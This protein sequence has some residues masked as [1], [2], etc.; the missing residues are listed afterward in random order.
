ME[1]RACDWVEGMRQ[2]YEATGDVEPIREV[3]PA[4]AAQMQ[5]FLNR[6]TD[7]GL[8]SARDWVVWGN[9]LGYLTGQTTTLNAFVQRALTDSAFLAGVIGKGE[10]RVKFS[11]A[12]HDLATAI[13]NVLW[14]EKSGGYYSGYFSEADLKA[15]GI[16][17]KLP[18]AGLTP[19]NL[20]ANVFALD[21]GIVPAERRQRVIEAMLTQIPQK[22]RGPIMI[23][24]Y[25]FKQL[26]ALDQ[27]KYDIQVLS[28]LRE[29]WK[30]M[31]ASPLQCSWE[32]FDGGSRAHIYGMYPG[33]FLSAYVLG[34]R[35]DAPVSER[36]LRIEPHLGDLTDAS[37]V[38]VTEFGPVA[39]SWKKEGRRVSFEVTSPENAQTV[40]AVPG[41][42]G[43]NVIQLDGHSQSAKLQGR[44][45]ILLLPR[46]KHRGFYEVTD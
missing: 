33:Y 35:R 23:F 30:G 8:I 18:R 38:V 41:D 22:Y 10:E 9:P 2:Y 5:Y 7:R 26:Y 17:P 21:Q 12:A 28:A 43:H 34:V 1:D 39:V 11:K 13:N 4:V 44:R 36:T 25:V 14:D 42:A 3:W 31:V 20:H 6:R 24:Y 15:T 37:G 45:L 46:G 16:T 19:T 29:G 40:L 32:A 27:P